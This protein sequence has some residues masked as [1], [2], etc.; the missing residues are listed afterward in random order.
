[1][2][3]AEPALTQSFRRKL[4]RRVIALDPVIDEVIGESSTLRHHSPVLQAAVGGLFAALAGW[5][6]VAVRL[7]RLPNARP[8]GRPT[9]LCSMFHRSSA[10]RWTRGSR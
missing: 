6:T 2:R 9:S 8:D 5:R 10:R 7:A 1:M 3:E 4:V